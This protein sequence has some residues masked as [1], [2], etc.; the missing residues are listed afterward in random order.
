MAVLR[1]VKRHHYVRVIPNCSNGGFHHTPRGPTP[2]TDSG[3]Q[4]GFAVYEDV[5]PLVSRTWSISI[6]PFLQLYMKICNAI[7]QHITPPGI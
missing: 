2:D 4:C 1:I 7:L 3:S 6:S 5:R